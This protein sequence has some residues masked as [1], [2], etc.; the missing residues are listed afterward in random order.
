[1]DQCLEQ[2]CYVTSGD[3][4]YNH[5]HNHEPSSPS[6]QVLNFEHA[7]FEDKFVS[8]IVVNKA[9]QHAYTKITI[10]LIILNCLIDFSYFI[11]FNK[12]HKI[13]DTY[14]PNI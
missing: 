2:N 5:N 14:V 6:S 7:V 13:C 12:Y 1:M 4:V 3:S 10:L 11:I 9:Y 8:E